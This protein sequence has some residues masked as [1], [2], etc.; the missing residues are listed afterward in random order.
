MSAT[1]VACIVESQLIIS[2]YIKNAKKTLDPWNSSLVSRLG[3]L[4]YCCFRGSKHSDCIAVLF[5]NTIS[6]RG[7][8]AT[9]RC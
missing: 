5:V 7:L 1:V 9:E 2:A 4:Q 8:Q 6:Q 3:L